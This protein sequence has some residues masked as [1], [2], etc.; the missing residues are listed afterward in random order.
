MKNFIKAISGHKALCVCIVL[1]IAA[2]V[3]ELVASIRL[4]NYSFDYRGLGIVWTC[5]A[6][7]AVCVEEKEKKAESVKE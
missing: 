7:W 4:E 3:L 2:T 1:T 5:I 6:A